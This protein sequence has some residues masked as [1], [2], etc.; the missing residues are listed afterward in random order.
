MDGYI[1]I[2]NISGQV[3]MTALITDGAH[4][5]HSLMNRKDITLSFENG[6]RIVLPYGSYIEYN[7]E[8]YNLLDEYVPEYLG[9]NFY[10]YTPVFHAAIIGAKYKIFARYTP[11]GLSEFDFDFDGYLEKFLPLIVKALNV[12]LPDITWK[13]GEVPS[14]G[15]L[16][17]LTFDRTDIFSAA[18]YIANEFGVEWWV[19]G[20]DTINFGKCETGN[21]TT[22]STSITE[23]EDHSITSGG[24]VSISKDGTK[25]VQP[26]Y[27]YAYGSTK[28]I[29]RETDI[30]GT[31]YNNRLHLPEGVSY[32]EVEGATSG[33]ESVIFYDDIFPKV[34]GTLSEVKTEMRTGEDGKEY[35]IYFVRDENRGFVLRDVTIA[36][37]VP[38]IV[39]TSGRL[40][41]RE[42]EVNDTAQT[43]DQ[44]DGLME[45][46]AEEQEDILMPNETFRPEVGDKYFLY[47]ILLPKEKEVE[48]QNELLAKAT[49]EAELLSRYSAPLTCTANEIEFAKRNIIL[50]VGSRLR[51]ED[52]SLKEG[53]TET[54]ITQ[55]EYNLVSPY[56]PTFKTSS[57]ISGGVIDALERK[58][59]EI[60]MNVRIEQGEQ[61]HP[62]RGRSYLP[63]NASDIVAGRVF[64][65]DFRQAGFDGSGAGL[66]KDSEGSYA[67]EIDKLTVRKALEVYELVINQISFITNETVF[68]NGGCEIERVEDKGS[69]WRCY[70]DNKNSRRFSGLRV[71]DQVRCQRLNADSSNV[72]KYYWRLVVGTGDDYVDISK[73]DAD[74]GSGE[75][76]AGDNIVQ[77]GNRIDVKRQGAKIIDAGNMQEVWYAGINSYNLSEKNYVGSGVNPQ[78]NEAFNYA[79]GDVFFGDRDLSKEEANFITYQKPEGDV[80]RK[81]IVSG[82]IRIGK[83]SKGLTNLSE[84]PDAEQ[85]IDNAQSTADSA[86][87]SLEN[88]AKDMGYTSLEEYMD[89]VI[90]GKT[91]IQGGY[92]RT[93]LINA[94]AIIVKHIEAITGHIAN[95][96]IQENQLVGNGEKIIFSNEALPPLEELIGG[97]GE[98]SSTY[99]PG[100]EATATASETAAMSDGTINLD[101]EVRTADMALPYA[102]ILALKALNKAAITNLEQGGMLSVDN[103]TAT[104]ILYKVG[105]G[106]TLTE[107]ARRDIPAASTDESVDY[108]FYIPEAGTYRLEATAAHRMQSTWAQRPEGTP[109]DIYPT[110]TLDAALGILGA[111]TDNK[112]RFSGSQEATQI[113]TDGFYSFWSLLNYL[114]FSQSQGLKV[115]GNCIISSPNGENTLTID[116]NGISLSVPAGAD[117]SE[118]TAVFT[119]AGARANIESGEKLKALF[120]KIKKWFADMKTVAFTGAYSDLTGTP[121]IPSVP[122]KV[123]AFTNDAGYI[124]KAVSDL[125]N[126]YKKSETYT[127]TEITTLIQQARSATFRIVQTL[128]STG[129]ANVIYLLPKSGTDGDVYDEYLW[130]SGAWEK[131]GTTE[132][133]LSDYYTKSQSDG[134]YINKTGDASNTTATFV[135]ATADAEITSGS[136]LSMLFGQTKRTFTSLWASL[137]GKLGKTEKAASATISDTVI[138]GAITT[139]KIADHAITAPKLSSDLTLPGTPQIGTPGALNS[140]SQTI[141][142]I[143]NVNAAVDAVQIGGTNIYRDTLG[144]SDFYLSA[145]GEMKYRR[146]LDLTPE[147]KRNLRGQS[148]SVSFDYI[149]DNAVVGRGD[150]GFGFSVKYTDGT[151]TYVNAFIPAESTAVT[152]SGR[153]SATTKIEDKEIDNITSFQPFMYARTTSGTATVGRPK[154]EIGT[155]ATQWSPAPEEMARKSDLPTVTLSATAPA[156]PKDGD[157]WIVPLS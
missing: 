38:V 130:L 55:I 7:G 72:I 120:G 73:S 92:I 74:S 2:K 119:Q 93:E 128:P 123:S 71:D 76:E 33:A 156:N 34:V 19:S 147:A 142:T 112:I 63:L 145:T 26:Q 59:A 21:I 85:H 144:T 134:K 107:K 118:Y 155:K 99:A 9:D 139:S 83:G 20:G 15:E 42:F 129:E 25:E 132:I 35:P 49:A 65:Y 104:L 100:A 91:I 124:T 143:G 105:T 39:F 140:P 127:Q 68:S 8:K 13:A 111:T 137:S 96:A 115:K 110:Y 138:D 80:A 10:Q 84:W 141:A 79:Y 27:L 97:A 51:I 50:S 47:N 78:T 150:T 116:D 23:Q 53:F 114:Y 86:I 152:R 37:M 81:M 3:I 54:R 103:H 125:E 88:V 95:F 101:L 133:D 75:P 48:A 77:F 122:T 17:T 69:F 58:V 94:A 4:F 98:E 126:Y 67:L 16:K 11:A 22:L 131:I 87:A 117:A 154:F 44:T 57:S 5:Y 31:S 24:L 45:I 32:V 70:Y 66:Y 61:Y 28:N 135:E 146:F 41:G 12:S 121:T 157:I 18:N 52:G 56:A 102:G 108:T 36:G 149:L 153:F 136:T 109:A 30:D 64:T 43:A 151:N 113:G 148:L 29:Q 40:N 14:G 1:D 60:G 106:G 62:L 90:G 46:F 89:A 82:D 6:E